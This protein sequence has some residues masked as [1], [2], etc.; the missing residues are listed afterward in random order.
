[1]GQLV[2][3]H[4]RLSQ[5]VPVL[6]PA[7]SLQ[8]LSEYLQYTCG[9]ELIRYVTL[10]FRDRRGGASL[11]YRNHAEITVLMC[12]KEALSGMISVP[13]QKLSGIA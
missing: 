3:P 1:M 9:T 12:E 5:W 4:F 11:R 13:A 2:H 6:F 7:H 8:L 10:H